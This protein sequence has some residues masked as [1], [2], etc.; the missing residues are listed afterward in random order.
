MDDD[1]VIN[2]AEAEGVKGVKISTKNPV[3]INVKGRTA[4]MKAA[5]KAKV[6][7][8]KLKLTKG[9]SKKQA[10]LAKRKKVVTSRKN[11]VKKRVR[12]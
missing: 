10:K 8:A 5:G 11:E 12:A 6:A 9:S 7:A 4:G 3:K 2:F 1:E